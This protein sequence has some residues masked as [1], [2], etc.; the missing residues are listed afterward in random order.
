MRI[1][2]F[3]FLFFIG[4]KNNFDAPVNYVPLWRLLNTLS[5]NLASST[6]PS[7]LNYSGSPYTWTVGQKINP[8][9]PAIVG[10]PKSYSIAPALPSGISLDS[11]T[12]VISGTPNSTSNNTNYIITASNS[13]G[14]TTTSIQITVVNR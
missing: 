3:I 4:C 2:L 9:A 11:I 7:N 1:I 8:V 12:G 13:G 14:Q 10:I 5:S 6:P